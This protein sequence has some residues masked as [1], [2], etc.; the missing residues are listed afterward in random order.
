MIGH[1]NQSRQKTIL[2]PKTEP[3]LDFYSTH[4]AVLILLW[5]RRYQSEN[6]YLIVVAI[7]FFC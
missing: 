2:S 3:K 6:C 4:V 5:Y 7:S 1:T